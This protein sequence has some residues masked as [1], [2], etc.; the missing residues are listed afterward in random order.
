MTDVSTSFWR[1]IA[2]RSI[3]A[4]NSWEI[5]HTT[6]RGDADTFEISIFMIRRI[7][8]G[9]ARSIGQTLPTE[10]SQAVDIAHWCCLIGVGA[11]I[12]FVG[13]EADGESGNFPRE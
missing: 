4:C 12:L 13:K 1:A 2:T 5:A 3:N 6:T 10:T 8:V 7:I 11:E 9:P